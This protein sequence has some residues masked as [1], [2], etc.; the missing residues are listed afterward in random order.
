MYMGYTVAAGKQLFPC[1]Q[2][3]VSRLFGL[4]LRSLATTWEEERLDSKAQSHKPPLHFSRSV[5]CMLGVQTACAL[6][7]RLGTALSSAEV[8]DLP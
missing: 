6:R 8:A 1:M 3:P 5:L 4:W 2:V 7:D